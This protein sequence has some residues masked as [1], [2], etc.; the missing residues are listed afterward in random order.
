MT[1]TTRIAPGI[2]SFTFKGVTYEVELYEDGL[3]NSFEIRR[4]G[5]REYLQTYRTKGHAVR[6]IEAHA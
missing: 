2:Y 4:D 6:D 1:K 5:D 3:W